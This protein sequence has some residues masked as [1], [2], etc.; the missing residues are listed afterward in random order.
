ML[1]IDKQHGTFYVSQNLH[2]DFYQLLQKISNICDKIFTFGDS[3]M[4]L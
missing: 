4:K 1:C 2:S 3:N